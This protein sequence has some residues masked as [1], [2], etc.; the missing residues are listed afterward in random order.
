MGLQ[1][2][3]NHMI[4]EMDFFTIENVGLDASNLSPDNPLTVAKFITAVESAKMQGNGNLAKL[5][6]E[7]MAK[8]GDRKTP[9]IGI[10]G[11]GGAG[12]SSLT[13]ELILR[14]LFDQKDIRLA[15]ISC[16]PSRRKTGGALL[17][18]RIRMNAINHPRVYMRS[19]ATRRSS[20][21][22]PLAL[23][24]AIEVIQAAGFDLVIAETAG[25]G[26][27]DSNI[28][29]LVDLSIYVMTSEFGAAT[30][31]EKIDML[32]FADLIVVNKYEKLGGEDAV[33]N[34]RKQDQRNLKAWH[35]PLEEMPVYG[36]IAFSSSLRG[37]SWKH[38]INHFASHK[39][40]LITSR[41]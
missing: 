36:T 22:I 6:A 5:R 11:T 40:L 10:T 26:Q 31:L 29:D 20:T 4:K 30:Q 28:I 1:G 25:I 23:T 14:I 33:R 13:D 39:G 41:R 12:K 9:I 8:I 15:I 19:L 7:L 35:Q 3:V 17:G 2:M 18:D 27:G 37:F 24:A 21:E 34:V 32:D 38:G 16:D